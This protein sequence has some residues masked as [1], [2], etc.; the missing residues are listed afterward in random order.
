MSKYDLYNNRYLSPMKILVAI[1]FVITFVSYSC[2]KKT[3]DN[4]PV[5][6]GYSL[7]SGD[8]CT[9]AVIAGRI[10]RDTPLTAANTVTI[11]VDVTV[12]G[13]YWITTNVV[14]GISFSQVSSFAAI[15]SQ[16]AVLT[17]SGTPIDTGKVYFT[18]TPL[19]GAGG[20]CTFSVSTIRGT[21]PH[22][23]IT[24]FLNGIYRNFGDSAAATNGSFPGTSG[25]PGLDIRGID[26]VVNSLSTLDFGVSN[27]MTVAAGNYADTSLSQ[28][29]LKYVDDTAAIWSVQNSSQP[30]F[31]INVNSLSTVAVSGTFSGTV[32]SMQGTGTDSI[33]VTNGKFNVPL[34]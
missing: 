6:A 29:Y 24:C 30:S 26:T 19:D 1:A 18:L 34:K 2:T 21:P 9:S 16:T 3:S 13:P 33:V 10:V 28:A 8:S 14:N 32:K 22:Y 27:V 31:I 5:L 17:G 15:G 4:P 12:P 20:S 23:Y 11:K 7:G 25:F